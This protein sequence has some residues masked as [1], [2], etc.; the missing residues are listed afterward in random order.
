[1]MKHG[2]LFF[3]ILFICVATL[4]IGNVACNEQP[5]ALISTIVEMTEFDKFYEAQKGYFNSNWSRNA[6]LLMIAKSI[7]RLTDAV[8]EHECLSK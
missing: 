5:R 1:M 2:F 6:A 3:M 4:Y 7:D 8:K